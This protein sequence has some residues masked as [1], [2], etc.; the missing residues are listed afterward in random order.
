MLKKTHS[1][2]LVFLSPY[3]LKKGGLPGHANAN[4]MVKWS[5][6]REESGPPLISPDCVS[7]RELEHEIDRLHEELEEIRK[8]GKRRFSLHDERG[9]EWRKEFRGKRSS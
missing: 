6:R 8:A 9:E 3:P 5:T 4:V 7:L 1:L 2:D